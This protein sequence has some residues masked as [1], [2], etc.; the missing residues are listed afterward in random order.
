MSSSTRDGTGR[1]YRARVTQDKRLSTNAVTESVVQ[2]GAI[3]GNTYNLATSPISIT[4]ST[5]TALFY[6]KNLDE[7]DLLISSIF[8]NTVNGSGSISG[9]PTLNIFR[10]PI[11]GLIVDNQTDIS[12]IS[13][14]NFGTNLFPNVNAYEGVDG[15][16]FTSFN[17][18]IPVPLPTRAAVPFLEFNTV[19][20]LERGSTY[21]ISY[22]P[23]SGS[24]SV[25]VIT[26]CIAT[27]LPK[28]F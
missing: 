24:T 22:Q 27:V 19:V 26:G 6:L 15:S 2:F 20:V 17:L 13:N 12:V 7:Q 3:L 21:G 8:I 5:E 28:E 25:D 18:T 10:N 1:G 9:Q 16:T 23:E 11:A 4:G 14:N